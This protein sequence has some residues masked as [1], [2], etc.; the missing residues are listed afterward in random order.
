M[1]AVAQAEAAFS[2]ND[3]KDPSAEVTLMGGKFFSN[4][5]VNGGREL[6]HEIMKKNEKDTHDPREEAR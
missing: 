6:S 3:M 4:V 5:W 1:K 2:L